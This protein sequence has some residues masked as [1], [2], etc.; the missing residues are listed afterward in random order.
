MRRQPAPRFSTRPRRTSS[1]SGS[2]WRTRRFTAVTL[3]IFETIW[4]QGY[5]NAGVVLQSYLYRS[6]EDARRMNALG[7]RVRLV[8]APTTR[9]RAVAYQAKADVDASFS[10]IMRLLLLEGT[11][12]GDRDARSRR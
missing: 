12:P 5:R 6:E 9:E 10:R 8:R 3:D 2:T 1:S 11:Y 4:Q 7:A